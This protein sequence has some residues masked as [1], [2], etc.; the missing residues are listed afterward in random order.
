MPDDGKMLWYLWAK[1][2]SNHVIGFLKNIFKF[3]DTKVY[4]LTRSIA[5]ARGLLGLLISPRN[6]TTLP[7]APFKKH[8]FPFHTWVFC[9]IVF[10]T[11]KGMTQATS[12]GQ[13][14]CST[15]LGIRAAKLGSLLGPVSPQSSLAPG[16]H[17]RPGLPQICSWCFFSCQ[18][19][20][21]AKIHGDTG[22]WY[23]LK[24]VEIRCSSKD[25]GV[26]CKGSCSHYREI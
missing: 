9:A 3:F 20:K 8:Q 14:V 19:L 17:S 7:Y 13:Y 11:F 25:V 26:L 24:H 21:R 16:S 1:H 15:S 10:V 12:R 22:T 6:H 18:D 2:G 5:L 23:K 4:M